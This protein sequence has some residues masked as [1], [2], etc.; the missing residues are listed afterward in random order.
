MKFQVGDTVMHWRHGLGQII[1]LEELSVM[2]KSQLCYVVQIRD[3]SIWVPADALLQDR[4]RVPVSAAAFKKLFGILSGPAE[5]LPE[6]RHERK[7][8]LSTRLADGTAASRCQVIRDLTTRSVAKSL[9]DDDRSTL[10]R[11]RSMLVAE[12]GYS[13]QIP[14]AQAEDELSRLLKPPP[15]EV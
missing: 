9:N 4:L 7:S 14:P 5:S 6:E 11:A 13:L 8:R 15:S 3:L 1:D 10:Q 2:G 12:W